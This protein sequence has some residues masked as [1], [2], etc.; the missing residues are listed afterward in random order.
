[1]NV[2]MVNLYLEDSAECPWSND[3]SLA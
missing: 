3:C 1:V 2:Q